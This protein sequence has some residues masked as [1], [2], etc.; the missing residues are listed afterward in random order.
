MLV[1]SRHDIC[2]WYHIQILSVFFLFSLSLFFFSNFEVCKLCQNFPFIEHFFLE[3]ALLKRIFPIS[4]KKISHSSKSHQE[5]SLFGKEFLLF[6]HSRFICYDC[7][8][9]FSFSPQAA[10]V[11]ATS[12]GEP[13]P[14]V[15][16]SPSWARCLRACLCRLRVCD[17]V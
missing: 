11:I 8:C 17:F 7:P 9:N 14:T 15:A 16:H 6:F 1:W 4:S 5:K 2:T 13:A 10:P 12:Q 3:F